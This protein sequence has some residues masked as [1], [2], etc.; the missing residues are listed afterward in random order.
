MADAAGAERLDFGQLA[1]IRNVVALFDLLIKPL[2]VGVR[3]I[4]GLLDRDAAARGG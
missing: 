4:F 1:R 2:E 3:F